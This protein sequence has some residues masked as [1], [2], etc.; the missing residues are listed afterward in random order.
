MT[1]KPKAIQGNAQH[2]VSLGSS[3]A[4][5]ARPASTPRYASVTEACRGQVAKAPRSD[6][7]AVGHSHPP[8]QGQ[9]DA[10]DHHADGGNVLYDDID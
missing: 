8:L 4:A 9:R 1:A 2:G 6:K 5:T 10:G 3:G 7:D